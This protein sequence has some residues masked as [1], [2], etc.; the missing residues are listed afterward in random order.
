MKRIWDGRGDAEGQVYFV[1]TRGIVRGRPYVRRVARR[2]LARE[3]LLRI[4]ERDAAIAQT[5]DNDAWLAPLDGMLPAAVG[6]LV[7]DMVR[8]D[9]IEP[10]APGVLRAPA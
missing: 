9:R 2:M 5:I 10:A 8:T 3:F 7:C 4:P 1:D 6:R